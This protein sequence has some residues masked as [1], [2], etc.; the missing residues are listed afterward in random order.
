MSEAMK[1]LEQNLKLYDVDD[2]NYYSKLL[3]GGAPAKTCKPKYGCDK[4][5]CA[6]VCKAINNT[7]SLI[8][9]ELIRR[10]EDDE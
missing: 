3:M 2:L 6:C 1:K 8:G 4:C 10:L 5:P 7:L 9:L